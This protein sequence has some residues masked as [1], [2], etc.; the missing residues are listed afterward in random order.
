[1]DVPANIKQMI[2]FVISLER[3]PVISVMLIEVL[4]IVVTR[5]LLFSMICDIFH[6]QNS[7]MIQVVHFV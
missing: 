1:M 6:L 2:L 7:V 5:M 4:P 3:L